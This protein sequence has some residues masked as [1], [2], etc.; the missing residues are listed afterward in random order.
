MKKLLKL[1][2]G[3]TFAFI[4][5]LS[6]TGCGKEE[7]K[8][9]NT[10]KPSQGQKANK[11]NGN[12]WA[13]IDETN[14]VAIIK[15]KTGINLD[16]LKGFTWKS[17]YGASTKVADITGN[18]K[19]G[20]TKAAMFESF[21]KELLRVSKNSIWSTDVNVD[22]YRIEKV[23]EY[24]DYESFFKW[25]TIGNEDLSIDLSGSVYIE[26]FQVNYTFTDKQLN[27]HIANYLIK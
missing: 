19:D 25:K 21:I 4:M 15:E 14:Y 22:T 6:L 18:Y 1:S 27:I 23:K 9:N 8:L 3:V 2:L 11:D 13:D 26:N 17:G 10:N 12:E 24:K 16:N 20:T 7:N 5:M